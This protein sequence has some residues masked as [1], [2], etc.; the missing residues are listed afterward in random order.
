[1]KFIN[2][3]FNNMVSAERI[4]TVASPDSAPIKRLVQDSR[5]FGRVIDCSCGRKTRSVI[6]TDSDHVILSA[7]QA[8]TLAGRLEGRYDTECVEVEDE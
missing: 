6:V 1:M 4:I 7:I 8:E 5:D 3:G 2:I